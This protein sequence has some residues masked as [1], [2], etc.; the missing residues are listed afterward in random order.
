MI[1]PFLFGQYKSTQCSFCHKLWV[2]IKM[3]GDSLYDATYN[4]TELG[5]KEKIAFL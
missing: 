2:F 5:S 3:N 4:G 1:T